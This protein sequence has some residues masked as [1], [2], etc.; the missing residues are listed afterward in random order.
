MSASPSTYDG[1]AAVLSL[2][3]LLT[4][5][6]MLRAPL[7]RSQVRLYA[8]QSLVVTVLAVYV[9]YSKHID[10]LYVLAALSLVLKV[11]LVPALI[12]RLLRDANT[13]LAGSSVVGVA[14]AILIALVVAA[15][16]FFSVGSLQ[17]SSS[18]LPTSSL[19]IACA[20]VLVAFVLIILRSDVVSQAIGF[21]SLENGVSVASLVVASG[22]P[23]IV[24]IAFLFDL[25]VAVVVFGVIMRVH[26]ARNATLSTSDFDRLKG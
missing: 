3:V 12:L 7:L 25:L 4:E 9:A 13:D 21:F 15:F 5:F 24:D 8:F 20:I 26:H 1:V 19:A 2:L 14:S 6:A 10:E 16:G 11:A 17:V 18:S 22:L 23:L